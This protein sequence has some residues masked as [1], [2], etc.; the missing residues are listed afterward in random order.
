MLLIFVFNSISKLHKR[1]IAHN[2]C[3]F[4]S[5]LAP[6]VPECVPSYGLVSDSA[7]NDCDMA[8]KCV[9]SY[10][11]VSDGV[12]NDCDM[13]SKCVPSYGRVSGGVDNDCD[14]TPQCV[15]S[16]GRVSDGVDNDC[17]GM[18][19]EDTCTKDDSCKSHC[20]IA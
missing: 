9:P 8:S 15:P 17:D 4:V 5:G 7:D 2:L 16:Y 20:S 11:R 18:I 13:A 19:D 14:M 10:G 1:C 6:Q 3:P 12:D